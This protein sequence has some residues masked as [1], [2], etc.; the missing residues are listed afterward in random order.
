MAGLLLRDVEIHGHGR[1]DCRTTDGTITEI[2]PD[3]EA[4]DE[5]VVEGHGGALLPGLADHHLHL[6]ATAAHDASVDLTGTTLTAALGG[7]RDG[8]DWI[9]V[10]GYDEVHGDL[11][12]HALDA[13]VGT[14]PVR[15]QHRSGA[16]WVVSSAG[17]E[18]LGAADAEHPGIERDADG[19]PTGRIWRADD[20]LADALGPQ[21]P[22]SL[23]ALGARLASYGITHVTD[24][25][26]DSGHLDLVAA[27]V[28][29][30]E[31]PQHVL[32]LAEAA[33]ATHPRLSIGPVKVVVGDHALPDLDVLVAR[34]ASAHAAGRP[35]AVHCVTRAGLAL[36]L[37]AL[38]T[39]GLRDG[40]RIE[41][42]AVADADLITAVAE[43]GLV[44][45]TQPCLVASRGDDYWE[46]SEPAD[47]A[48]LWPYAGL[49]EA[50]VR[51]VA[52]S[53]SPYGD[54]DPWAG[55][56]AAAARTTATGRVVGA[57]ERVDP[58]V[59]LA[60]LLTPL[61][62][63]GGTPRAITVGAGA[64]LVLLDRPLAE[65]LRDLDAGCVRMTLIEGLVAYAR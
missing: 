36:T 34:I 14:T 22:L 61:E 21:P 41:H 45:A 53:D 43:R 65:A 26:P 7:F 4:R 2:G 12:R 38:D 23:R 11:D 13:V 50:G 59:V 33:V 57:D 47:R 15:V 58:E 6:A 8:D 35:V 46:R 39:A 9:R 55:M 54:A 37:A 52:S 28:R 27:A 44:V 5:A 29:D 1:A 42:C 17:L 62:D 24:A 32:L 18:V 31:L 63:P 40:D 3:L 64:D 16:L 51:T 49:L 19:V 30:G 25:S 60:G 48:D 56:R 20:W 10:V